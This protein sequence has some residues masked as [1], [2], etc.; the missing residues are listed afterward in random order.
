MTNQP[1]VQIRKLIDEKDVNEFSGD[2]ARWIYLS[3]SDKFNFVHGG[4]AKAR[5]RL[6]RFVRTKSSF[7]S[8]FNATVAFL[9][10]RPAGT[11]IELEGKQVPE[12]LRADF[13]DLA[14]QAD[15]NERAALAARLSSLRETSRA[16]NVDEYYLAVLTV[17]PAYRGLGIGRRL[18]LEY[19]EHGRQTGYKRLRLDVRSDNQAALRLYEG[20]G[21]KPVQVTRAEFLGIS[22]ISFLLEV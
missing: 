8:G 10:M 4:E 22:T 3:A 21:F 1:H 12:S 6:E 2:I 20:H 5:A 14:R 17:D 13:F 11:T 15:K 18:L 9:D 19:I 7:F 16:I